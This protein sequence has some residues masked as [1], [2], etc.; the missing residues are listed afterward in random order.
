MLRGKFSRAADIAV[1]CLRRL[2]NVVI[3]R[4]SIAMAESGVA[5]AVVAAEALAARAFGRVA[6]HHLLLADRLS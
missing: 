6:S 4:S 1:V 3:I 5:A 2:I